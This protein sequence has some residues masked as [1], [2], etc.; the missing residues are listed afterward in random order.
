MKACCVDG[1]T[2]P[3]PG[4]RDEPSARSPPFMYVRRVLTLGGVEV[5]VRKADRVVKH[6]LTAPANRWAFT[7]V[8]TG[9]SGMGLYTRLVYQAW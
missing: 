5:M 7:P 4:A 2:A 1:G 6:R 9:T 3:R 8:C